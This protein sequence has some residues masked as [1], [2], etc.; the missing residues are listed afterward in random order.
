M[1]SIIAFI[2]LL[3]FIVRSLR[4]VFYQTYLWQLKEY[5]WDRFWS[6]L[7]THQ[8]R[9]LIFNKLSIFKWI[10]FIL[11]YIFPI[12][13]SRLRGEIPSFAV[14]IY[15]FYLFW[16]TWIL[17][18]VLSIR[19][20]Y[21]KKWRLP[22]FTPKSV[23]II[24]AVLSIQF[25]P[26]INIYWVSVLLL[27]PLLDKILAPSVV[28]SVTFFNLPSHF[29]RLII[30]KQAQFKIRRL[31][32]LKVIAIT[33]SFGKTSTKTFLEKILSA[34]YKV[35][36]T[37]GSFNTDLSV[38]RHIN[39]NLNENVDFFI[40]EMGAYR[41]GEINKICQLVSP[42]TGIITALGSQHLDL[43]GSRQ[44]L[45]KAKFELIDSLPSGGLAIINSPDPLL[46]PMIVKAKKRLDNM[47]LINK[48]E[49]TK[50]RQINKT[51][52]QF[53]LKL[54]N[55]LFHFKAN[56]IGEQNIDNLVL[57]IS[58]ANLLGVSMPVIQKE[59]STITPPAKTMQIV[60]D[61]KNLTL[62]DDTFNV[63]YEGILSAINYL[64]L[65][66]GLRVIFLNPLIELGNKSREFHQ[67]IGK[68]AGDICHFLITT[69]LNNYPDL[70]SGINHSEKRIA[71]LLLADNKTVTRIREELTYD[72]VILFAGKE[73]FK[74]ISF[75]I[76]I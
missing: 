68:K 17:E 9:Q 48:S 4:Q 39:L 30:Y 36:A 21:L 45:I 16:F 31:S 55:R 54:N 56:L 33:G 12:F 14:I 20:L 37:P 24:I 73:S 71:K 1:I 76:K 29:F 11:I 7:K 27:G 51:F 67:N 15:S 13:N 2:I 70:L 53:D 35:S 22:V 23:L 59:V 46:K 43:F 34:E 40:V 58:A 47:L 18:L 41:R 32:R 10:L 62:I 61:T 8:G 6:F 52:L 26:L 72:S 74:W 28:L 64:K 19:D 50:N 25:F 66:H 63:N 60:R 3:A 75:F 44:N 69:N 57:A 65:Y 42:H 5:R 49:M 38:A